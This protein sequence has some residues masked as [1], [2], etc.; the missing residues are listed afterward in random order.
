MSN[1]NN[2]TQST[3]L[4]ISSNSKILALFAIACTGLVGLVNELTK[5]KIKEQEQ[6]QLLSTLN[7]IIE[8]SRYDNNIAN[9]CIITRSPLLGSTENKKAYIARKNNNVVALAMTSTAPNGYNGN[10]DL[11]VGIN[12][13]A[14]ISGVRVLKHKE[15]PGLGDKIEINKNDWITSFNDKTLLSE[16][17]NRWTVIKDGGMFDQFTGAT[18]TPRA[19]VH[20]IKN[21]LTYFKTNK[22]NLL[23]LSNSC[24]KNTAIPEE[25]IINEVT[26]EQ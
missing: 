8:S 10:I 24:M 18:I 22:E 25:N 23:T 11:I 5:D 20:A 3:K 7:A 16:S 1:K 15:T 14:T 6:L 9:D 19:V 13:D 21:T 26:N 2:S 12:M 17:D 4:A